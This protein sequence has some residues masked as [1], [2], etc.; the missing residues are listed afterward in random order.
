LMGWWDSYILRRRVRVDGDGNKVH[1]GEGVRTQNLRISIQGSGNKILI[2]ARTVIR[3]SINISGDNHTVTVGEDGLLRGVAI[4]CREGCGLRIGNGVLTSTKVSIRT[5]DSHS[6]F[7]L[8]T[9]ER[10]NPGRPVMIGD[11]VWIAREVSIGKGVSIPND[12]IIAARSFV[13]KSFEEEH[14]LIGGMPARILKTG[15]TWAKELKARADD[16]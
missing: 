6:I 15:V 11:H 12:C 8:S 5:S 9:G 3:G 14:I 10:T 2:G 16:A 1:F 4:I 7:D 13:T